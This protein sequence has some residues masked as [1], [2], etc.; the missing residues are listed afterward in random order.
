[1]R[2]R[3]CSAPPDRCGRAFAVH[4]LHSL[5]LWRRL[6][7]QF[8]GDPHR[9]GNIHAFVARQRGRRRV[10]RVVRACETAPQKER[11]SKIVRANGLH[12]PAPNA[13]VDKQLFVVRPHGRAQ[14]IRPIGH[15]AVVGQRRPPKPRTAS[16]TS[17]SR[18]DLGRGGPADSSCFRR[19]C[20]GGNRTAGGWAQCASCRC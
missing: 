1:M 6:G 15:V 10:K 17:R 5:A 3:G 4:A 11:R 7:V 9:V 14:V 8:V 20:G 13:V 12:A 2:F 18:L 16:G 19:P